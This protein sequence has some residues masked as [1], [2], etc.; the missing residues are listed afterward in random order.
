MPKRSFHRSR[1]AARALSLAVHTAADELVARRSPGLRNQLLRAAASVPANIAEAEQQTS[2]AQALNFLRVA[3]GSADEVG[4]H[5]E[6]AADAGA[7][8]PRRYTACQGT[9]QVVKTMLQRLIQ[10][11]EQERLPRP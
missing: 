6:T 10:R 5:L 4:A 7:L 3:L 1:S 9:R 8:S 2:D 11:L